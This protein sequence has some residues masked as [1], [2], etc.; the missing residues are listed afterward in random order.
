MSELLFV[1]E[2]RPGGVRVVLGMECSFYMSSKDACVRDSVDFAVTRSHF[3]LV[4]E[5]NVG[6]NPL[7]GPIFFDIGMS[8]LYIVSESM[9]STGMIAKLCKN[10]FFLQFFICK[11]VQP[12]LEPNRMGRIGCYRNYLDQS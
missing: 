1:L 9:L 7:V 5:K 10:A 12:R 6:S 2:N 11:L 3:P 4:S 8:S